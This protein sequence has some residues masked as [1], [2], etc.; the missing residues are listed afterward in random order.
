MHAHI[1]F[2]IPD[3]SSS[4]G[5]ELHISDRN[6]E[7]RSDWNASTSTTV[8]QETKST[9]KVKSFLQSCLKLIRDGNSQLEVQ[10]LIDYCDPTIEREL[11]QIKRYIH[12]G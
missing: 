7:L 11:N 4:K 5:K 10:R 8:C 3:P 9:S 2:C 12:T 6:M 1:K